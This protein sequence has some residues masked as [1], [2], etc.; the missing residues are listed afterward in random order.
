MIDARL[1]LL[2]KESSLRQSPPIRGRWICRAGLDFGAQ[3]DAPS[4]FSSRRIEV[5]TSRPEIV[6]TFGVVA[7][8]HWL[9][10][11]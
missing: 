6:G 5:I 10:T 11:N 3:L 2:R 9:A 7:T 1:C 4:R 8:T